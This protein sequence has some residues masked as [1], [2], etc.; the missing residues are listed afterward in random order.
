[1]T[2]SRDVEWRG[3]LIVESLQHDRGIWHRVEVTGRSK[4]RLENEGSRG[5][6]TFCN[7]EVVE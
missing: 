7:V 4:Q 5:E 2:S 6:F 1:M 3:V